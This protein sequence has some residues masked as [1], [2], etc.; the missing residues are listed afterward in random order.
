[1]GQPKGSARPVDEA[2]IERLFMALHGYFGNQFLDKFRLGD[3]GTGK[4]IGIENAKRT[5]LAELSGY[6]TG[7]I[8]GGLQKIKDAGS[9]FPPGLPEFAAACKACRRVKAF[10]EPA[11]AL[12]SPGAQSVLQRLTEQRQRVSMRPQG[13]LATLYSVISRAVGNAGGDEVA[14]LRQLE[15]DVYPRTGRKA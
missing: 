8:F 14:A 3:P 1:M 15:S 10:S 2:V 6:T 9:P 12:P 4:D 13:G 7:E 5:W 11:R